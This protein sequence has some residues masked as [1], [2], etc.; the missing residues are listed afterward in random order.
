M[1]SFRLDIL[2]QYNSVS[3]LPNFQRFLA[4]SLYYF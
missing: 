3:V 2:H 4:S 1:V